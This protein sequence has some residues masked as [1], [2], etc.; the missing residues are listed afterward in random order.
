[1]SASRSPHRIFSKRIA[2]FAFVSLMLH[3]WFW[4]NLQQLQTIARNPQPT[5]IQADLI[6]AFE[7]ESHANET[8]A[9]AA[10]VKPQVAKRTPSKPRLISEADSAPVSNNEANTEN[11]D[12]SATTTAG[13]N[14]GKA[15]EA[16]SEQ[17][18]EESKEQAKSRTKQSANKKSK[19][20]QT[21][22]QTTKIL[23][24]SIVFAPHLLSI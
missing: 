1:M 13:E 20:Q 9:P 4:Q 5:T 8:L 22:P 19:A 7:S 11:T 3:L 15:N 10:S 14:D 6:S 21:K 17:A 24:P 23:R 16:A 18:K 12:N 2:V